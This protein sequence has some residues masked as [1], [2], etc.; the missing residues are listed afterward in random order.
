MGSNPI[1]RT[2]YEADEVTA[3]TFHV[4]WKEAAD[5]GIHEQHVNRILEPFQ[6]IKVIITVWLTNN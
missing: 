3:T 4:L 5:L 1:P 6:F 2:N